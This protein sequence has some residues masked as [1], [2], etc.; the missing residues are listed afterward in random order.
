[1]SIGRSDVGA[2]LVKGD[3]AK[4]DY[5]TERA[6]RGLGP[7]SLVSDSWSLG[8]TYRNKLIEPGDPIAL[9]IG[10]PRYPGIVEIGTITEERFTGTWS[11]EYVLDESER[12]KLREFITYTGVILSQPVPR[13]ALKNDPHLRHSEVVRQ[14][15]IT[16][17]SYLTPEEAS[18]LRSLVVGSDLSAAGW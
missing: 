16:N 11:S 13:S 2:W 4:W 7:G 12:N 5:W 15:Q 10:G 6:D 14:G 3:P 9:Y 8:S 17:P 1:M 18:V